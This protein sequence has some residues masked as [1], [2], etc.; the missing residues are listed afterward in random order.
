MKNRM[1][2]ILRGENE[3]DRWIISVL[4]VSVLFICTYSIFGIG[5]ETNDDSGMMY[6]LAG[7]R[8]GTPE[9]GTVYSN[10]VWDCILWALYSF[11][12]GMP[13]YGLAFVLLLFLSNVLILKSALKIASYKKIA[14]WK[15]F[16]LYITF[17]CIA[18]NYC[19]A[20]LQFTTL[21]AIVGTA[22]CAVIS[23]LF[24]GESNGVR[25][26]DAVFT[27]LF[28]VLSYLIRAKAGYVAAVW[29]VTAMSV[30]FI[31]INRALFKKRAIYFLSVFI[32]GVIL[33]GGA[34]IVH[35]HFY[36][37]TNWSEYR[38]FSSQRGQYKDYPHL[39]Y[40]EAPEVYQAVGWSEE[41]YNLV[42]RWF[43]MSPNINTQS[44]E[45][46]N[47]EYEK[48][49][50]ESINK[51]EIITDVKTI[52]DF[53]QNNCT[54]FSCMGLCVLLNMIYLVQCLRLKNF[55][56]LI[57]LVAGD[58][59][60]CGM[61]LYLQLEG[62]MP[63]RTFLLCLIP[64]LCILLMNILR[65]HSPIKSKSINIMMNLACTSLIF[66][67]VSTNMD[68][69]YKIVY[70]EM[71]LDSLEN[72]KNLER[73]FLKHPD[74][75]YVYDSSLRWYSDPLMVHRP[76]EVPNNYFFWGG[77]SMFSPLYYKQLEANGREELYADCFFDDDVYYVSKSKLT[78]QI[79]MNYLN[80]T[81]ECITEYK[82][83]DTVD[84]CS[85][86]QFSKVE[87]E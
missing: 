12:P 49:N 81:Y 29:C 14:L 19:I 85:I 54:A 84:G 25:M 37:E 3:L 33:S 8:T 72:K 47:R 9:I 65:M 51:T 79:F 59:I 53:I 46:L 43:F 44:F 1:I 27:V 11:V 86:V 61:L 80:N 13:W 38:D 82:I 66:M 74:N 63:Q 56:E 62:R 75:L 50:T 48:A 57:Y 28:I 76:E 39:T 35:N 5:F 67:L 40:E 68:S 58:G 64:W 17:Y 6:I 4:T 26:V 73:Y 2:K 78:M 22:A 31:R 24:Y 83:I 32:S 87:N 71:R 52:L 55:L 23:A 60:M 7:Y 21:S 20:L 77:A 16:F 18:V 45:S 30:K 36:S 10:V 69:L 41:L 34:L 70:S 15:C 42:I